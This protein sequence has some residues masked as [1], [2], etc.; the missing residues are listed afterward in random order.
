M[1]ATAPPKTVSVDEYLSNS[2]YRH[3]EYV[4]DEVVPRNIGS[5]THSRTQVRCGCELMKCVGDRVDG[6]VAVALH[7]RLNIEGRVRF[8]LPDVSVILNDTDDEAR[9]LNRAP[10]LAPSARSNPTAFQAVCFQPLESAREWRRWRNTGI[11][12]TRCST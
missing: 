10:D 1:G 9:Y 6:Y 2:E 3:S 12:R 8:R 5:K 7:C 11:A 4:D